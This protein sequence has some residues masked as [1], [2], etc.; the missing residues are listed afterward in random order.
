LRGGVGMPNCY[1]AV[2]RMPDSSSEWKAASGR[3]CERRVLRD[4]GAA[5]Q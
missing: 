1:V 4:G 2:R 5:F 3:V